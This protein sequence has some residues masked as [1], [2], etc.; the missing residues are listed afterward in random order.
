VLGTPD[1]LPIDVRIGIAFAADSSTRE[2]PSRRSACQISA[3]S[4][5]ASNA[6]SPLAPVSPATMAGSPGTGAA[7]AR[8][9]SSA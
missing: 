2:R 3:R 4:L 8:I 9:A 6:A 7:S 1:D 5:A